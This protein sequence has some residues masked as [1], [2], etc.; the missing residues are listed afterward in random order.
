MTYAY[1]PL[2]LNTHIQTI[3]TQPLRAHP[4]HPFKFEE[5]GLY[6]LYVGIGG[7]EVAGIYGRVNQVPP[8]YQGTSRGLPP[9]GNSNRM[10]SLVHEVCKRLTVN[11]LQLTSQRIPGVQQ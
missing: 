1:N 7:V 2:N 8:G 4:V 3:Q 9:K 10:K 5:L 6:S 11:Q